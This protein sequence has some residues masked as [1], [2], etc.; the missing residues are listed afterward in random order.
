MRIRPIEFVAALALAA[1]LCRGQG[2]ITTVAGAS[3]C[4]SSVDGSQATNFWLTGAGGITMDNLGN[5]YIWNGASGKIQ[6]V[7]AQ[8]II[9]TF[10]GNGT[11]G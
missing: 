8:G 5:L 9:G 1:T 10:A 3:K 2:I 6:K 11:F 4:C 7:N